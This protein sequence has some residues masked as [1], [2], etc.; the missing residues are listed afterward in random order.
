MNVGELLVTTSLTTLWMSRIATSSPWFV[1]V[2]KGVMCIILRATGGSNYR[3]VLC[4]DNL[5]WITDDSLH[6]MSND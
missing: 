3:Y 4:G 6:A 1:N 5:G 2:N